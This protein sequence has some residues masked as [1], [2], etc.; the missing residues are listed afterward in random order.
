MNHVKQGQLDKALDIQNACN[1]IISKLVSTNANL[2]A[3]MKLV[4]KEREGLE[5]G[6]V[7]RPLTN[8]DEETYSVVLEATNL[9]NQAIKQYI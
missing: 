9:I 3:V 5:L 1:A 8:V 7:R 2:Y 4:L 6:G